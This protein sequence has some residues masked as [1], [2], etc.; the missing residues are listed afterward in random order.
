MVST[1]INNYPQTY[2]QNRVEIEYESGT[3]I[4]QDSDP[5]VGVLNAPALFSIANV[6]EIDRPITLMRFGSL[7]S[8]IQFSQDVTIKMP[9][10]GK[11]E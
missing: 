11:N 9:A 5:F 6:P 8:S 7:E 1:N 10:L 2:Y 4:T 3:L